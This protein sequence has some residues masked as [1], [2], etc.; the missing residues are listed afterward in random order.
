M[1]NV[2]ITNQNLPHSRTHERQCTPSFPH[3][4]RAQYHVNWLV[5]LPHIECAA[6]GRDGKGRWV[7]L[8]LVVWLLAV[9]KRK[10]K[11][12]DPVGP[13]DSCM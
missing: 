7:L 8:M 3:N 12:L 10:V 6:G 2:L 4:V 13:V 5:R 9:G 1:A 11:G